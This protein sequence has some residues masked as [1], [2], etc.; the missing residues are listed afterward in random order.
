MTGINYG[1]S[2]LI[3]DILSLVNTRFE[4]RFANLLLFVRG[5]I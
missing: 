3:G 4:P 1:K 2:S 5:T